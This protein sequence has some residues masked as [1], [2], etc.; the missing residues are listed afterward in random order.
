MKEAVVPNDLDV[1]EE[2]LLTTGAKQFTVTKFPT[3]E[4]GK[5]SLHSSLK[6]TTISASKLHLSFTVINLQ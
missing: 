3:H 6:F 1:K 4:I 2:A 5:L